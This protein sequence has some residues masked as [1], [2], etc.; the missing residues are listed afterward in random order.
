[1]SD[2]WAG[3]WVIDVSDPG[4][5]REVGYYNTPG[6]A[7]TVTH[8][9]NWLY[10]ADCRVGLRVVDVSKPENPVEVGHYNTPD[11]VYGLD[12]VM[13]YVYTAVKNSGLVI[14]DASDPANPVAIGSVE[15]PFAC[16]VIVRGAY[17]YVADR[18]RGLLIVNISN[19]RNPVVISE[20][21]PGYLGAYGVAFSGQYAYLLNRLGY[22]AGFYVIDISDLMNPREVVFYDTPGMGCGISAFS[23]LVYVADGESCLRVI[24]ARDTSNLHE[25]GY[26]VAKNCVYRDVALW[27]N[28]AYI[29]ADEKGLK[30]I[31]FNEMNV[32]ENDSNNA[33]L[34]S[35]ASIIHNAIVISDKNFAGYLLD[36]TGRKVLDLKPGENNVR[37]LVPGVYFIKNRLT[38]AKAAR[39]VITH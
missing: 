29:A 33:T 19:P 4:N 11:W 37:A 36:V 5:P 1:M 6:W 28:Y 32:E 22:N 34:V 14:I 39:V 17:A 38:D 30:V 26:Y 31:A 15:S 8:R 21:N 27:R 7:Y 9:G 18:I 16:K 13:N 2:L 35:E 25:V 24:D 3:V 20:C 23:N 12:V 10:V